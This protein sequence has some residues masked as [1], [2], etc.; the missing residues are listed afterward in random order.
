M[1]YK[2][3]GGNANDI[4]SMPFLDGHELISYALDAEREERLFL[5]WAMGYQFAMEFEEFK[6]ILGG[7]GQQVTDGRTAAEIL[8]EVR[9][10]TG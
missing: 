7:N 8:S 9:D 6:G 3:Y 10:I 2:R 1:V 4:F 5:R